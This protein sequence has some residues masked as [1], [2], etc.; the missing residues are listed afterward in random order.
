MKWEVYQDF[1]CERKRKFQENSLENIIKLSV[2]SWETVQLSPLVALVE[3]EWSFIVSMESLYDKMNEFIKYPKNDT[4]NRRIWNEKHFGNFS[5]LLVHSSKIRHRFSS[6]RLF[7]DELKIRMNMKNDGI[8]IKFQKLQFYI[9]IVH[10][11]PHITKT[12][13]WLNGNSNSTRSGTSF[14]SSNWQ[15]SEIWFLISSHT[16]DLR[17]VAC[18]LS[19]PLAPQIQKIFQLNSR[20]HITKAWIEEKCTQEKKSS[21][22]SR[23]QK[24]RIRKY[25]KDWK[26]FYRFDDFSLHAILILSCFSTLILSSWL[27][28]FQFSTSF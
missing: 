10:Q 23:A 27:Y 17:L 15:Q 16:H 7:P 24:L 4:C 18:R 26:Q 25:S 14:P 13:I 20:C 8:K 28:T 11:K 3:F 22:E 9:S 6:F 12:S 1:V 5:A 19:H 21:E 2:H